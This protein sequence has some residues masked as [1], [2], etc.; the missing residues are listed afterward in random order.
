MAETSASIEIAATPAEVLA[1]MSSAEEELMESLLTLHHGQRGAG[2]ENENDAPA[3]P[4]RSGR[5][6]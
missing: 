5:A 3:T 1:V 4:R 2:A 6:R